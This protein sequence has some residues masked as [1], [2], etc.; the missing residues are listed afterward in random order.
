MNLCEH[1][2]KIPDFP[3]EGILFR[4]ITPLLSNPD[5][6]KYAISKMT[7]IAKDLKPDV[8]VGIESRGFMFAIPISMNLGLPF[9]PVRKKGKLP[10]QTVSVSYELEYGG[11]SLEIHTDALTPGTRVLI[12]DDL[13]AT[14]G[15]VK[16]CVELVGGLNAKVLGVVTLIDLVDIRNEDWFPDININSLIKY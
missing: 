5:A 3:R 1:I 13:I 15:T 9:V 12:V 8:I 4:D 2:R 7:G 6:F 16:A 11:D 14:G 10:Y